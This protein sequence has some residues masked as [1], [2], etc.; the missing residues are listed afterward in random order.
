MIGHTRPFPDSPAGAL[1][2]PLEF[3]AAFV[4]LHALEETQILS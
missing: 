2:A 3:P 4:R 1:I